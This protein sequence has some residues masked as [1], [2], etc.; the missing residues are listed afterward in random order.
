MQV[1]YEEPQQQTTV[2]TNS[3][4]ATLDQLMGQVA[5]ESKRYQNQKEIAQAR[6]HSWIR[7]TLN[8]VMTYLPE[9]IH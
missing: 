5:A 2:Q 8:R 6:A 3:L 7:D 9:W 4:H 1:R